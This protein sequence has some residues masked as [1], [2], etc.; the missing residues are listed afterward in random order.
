MG[1]HDNKLWI[2]SY[3]AQ[4]QDLLN[5]GA[6]VNGIGAQAHMGPNSIDL[7]KVEKSYN[8]LWN[9]FKFPIW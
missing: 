4:I 2:F 5:R 8:D 9:N 3:I 7:A 1:F 6:P